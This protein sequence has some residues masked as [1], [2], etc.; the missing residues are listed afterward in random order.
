MRSKLAAGPVDPSPRR[1]R[2]AGGA[3]EDYEERVRGA[4]HDDDD[5][6]RGEASGRSDA[7]E[8]EG[9]IGELRRKLRRHPCHACPDREQHAR[10]AE[11][12]FRQKR[13][14]DELERQVA[15]RSHVIARTFDRVCKVLDELGYL[16]GDSVTPAGQ[17]LTR[18]YSELDLVA[19]ECLRR[20]LWEG[21]NPAELAACVSVLSFESRKQTE[22]AGPARLP[23]GPV[24]DVLT[25][26]ARTWGELDHL[27][28][29][30]GLSFLRE[31]DAGFVWAAYRWARGAKLEDVLDSV[32]GLTP[33]DFV[34][35]MKQLIDLLD[36][37]AVASRDLGADAARR[38]AAGSTP[39]PLPDS[40][41][42]MTPG[43]DPA[44]TA[45]AAGADTAVAET[46]DTDTDDTDTDDPA[47]MDTAGMDTDDPETVG[48]KTGDADTGDAEAGTSGGAGPGGERPSREPAR[49]NR[50]VASTARAAIDAIRR[51]V[52]AYT[53]LTD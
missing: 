49:K 26:M 47:G 7:G 8:A 24:R 18:L 1:R 42:P 28:Q 11:R 52:I 14:A 23:K 17:R 51:G 9:D 36:Q 27:E 45:Q 44:G 48:P 30:N 37:I 39:A 35:S 41:T 19:A 34:R 50:D 21:L 53:T 38:K 4:S 20:G 13:E 6:G 29:R 22:D 2:S 46:D 31:P 40:A 10:Y 16:D 43:P 5:Y 33:G 15:G 25:D 3:D 32:P 12:Y